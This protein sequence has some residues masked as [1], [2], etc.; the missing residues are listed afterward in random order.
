MSSTLLIFGFV[1]LLILLFR[2]TR[3]MWDLVLLV[4]GVLSVGVYCSISANDWT[5]FAR[6]GSLLVVIS[7]SMHVFKYEAALHRYKSYAA[8]WPVWEEFSNFESD[9]DNFPFQTRLAE[10]MKRELRKSFLMFNSYDK[11]YEAAR[12]QKAELRIA[13]LGTLIWGFGDLLGR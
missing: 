9:A 3:R 2:P 5:W 6:M 12:Y 11:D 10:K 4:F 1:Y 8:K 13:I 7:A